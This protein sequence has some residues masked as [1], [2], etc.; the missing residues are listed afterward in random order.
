MGVE[1]R[2][3]CSPDGGAGRVLPCGG[4][5]GVLTER[6]TLVGKQPLDQRT[7]RL[8]PLPRL[9][10]HTDKVRAGGANGRLIG[11][12]GLIALIEN[13]DGAFFGSRDGF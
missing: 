2:G 13:G 5:D 7:K 12:G 3:K 9:G 4:E 10:R 11:D 6:D 1:C 8:A